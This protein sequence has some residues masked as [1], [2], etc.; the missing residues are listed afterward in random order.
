[1]NFNNNDEQKD[2]NYYDENEREQLI[3]IQNENYI[4]DG[5]LPDCYGD[6]FA[7]EIMEQQEQGR[8]FEIDKWDGEIGPHQTVAFFASRG[9]GKSYCIRDLLYRN[10]HKFKTVIIICPSEF[11]NDDGYKEIIPDCFIFDELNE[12]T[13]QM[14]H[15]L[16]FLRQKALKKKLAPWMKDISDIN[17]LII[18]DDCMTEPKKFLNG[19]VVKSLY[20][21]GRHFKIGLWTVVQYFNDLHAELRP[22]VDISIILKTDNK[23]LQA[24]FQDFVGKFD[25][26]YE[27]S[28]ILTDT[29]ENYGCFVKDSKRGIFWYKAGAPPK[30]WK[31]NPDQWNYH[32]AHYIGDAYDDNSDNQK[33]GIEWENVD[34]HAYLQ[35]G[36]ITPAKPA[37]STKKEKPKVDKSKPFNI[38]IKKGE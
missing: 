20:K 36:N 12:A 1:M 5:V 15:N 34:R 16:M 19:P 17:V 29:T 23:K 31:M 22:N 35:S 21:M 14:I 25:N 28:Q 18:M 8:A 24:K 33:P 3:N 9:G 6:A 11:V 37:S 7:E 2:E 13:V 4:Q 27:F 10:R 26:K 38:I 30:G 32:N